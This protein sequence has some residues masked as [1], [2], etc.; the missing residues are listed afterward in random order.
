MTP[1]LPQYKHS[2]TFV[3]FPALIFLSENIPSGSSTQA[4]WQGSLRIPKLAMNDNNEEA[5]NENLSPPT[6]LHF[7]LP[8][9]RSSALWC[10]RNNQP[11]NWSH[12]S[13]GEGRERIK[14]LPRVEV[15]FIMGEKSEKERERNGKPVWVNGSFFG[16]RLSLSSGTASAFIFPRPNE[17]PRALHR[18][19]RVNILPHFKPFT[20]A[21]GGF[22][23]IIS[24]G[25][26]TYA[27][28]KTGF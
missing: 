2:L 20:A 28:I 3:F 10:L 26:T 9:P 22:L 6:E 8:E 18:C 16:H 15:A 11:G 12:Y 24:I 1:P 14:N 7:N 21:R 23:K 19:C 5:G 27:G 13:F 4:C 25:V 17:C